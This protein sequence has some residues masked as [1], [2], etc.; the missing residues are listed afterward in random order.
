MSVFEKQIYIW[1][2]C[3]LFFRVSG[4]DS[5]IVLPRL[6]IFVSLYVLLRCLALTPKPQLSV[7]LTKWYLSYSRTPSWD[8]SPL[9]LL[10]R[11]VC[12]CGYGC[13]CLCVCVCVCMCICYHVCVVCLSVFVCVRVCLS[14]CVRFCV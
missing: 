12:V 3:L 13:L 5:S 2:A 14:E 6:H 4:A 9:S 10:L 1:V 8:R 11:C 7:L